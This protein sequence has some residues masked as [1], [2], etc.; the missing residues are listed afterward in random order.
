MKRWNKMVMVA[1]LAVGMA[2]GA[3][4]A[5]SGKVEGDL[6][7]P[8]KARAKASGGGAAK[9]VVVMS[10]GDGDQSVEVRLED[11]KVVGA[12][13]NGKEVPADRIRRK[14]GKVEILDTDGE[15]IQSFSVGGEGGAF[16]VGPEGQKL[17]QLLRLQDPHLF[18]GGGEGGEPWRLIAPGETFAPPKVML[19]INMGTPDDETTE[20]HGI[21]PAETILISKVIEGLP[22]DKAGI[23][24]GDIVVKIGGKSPATPEKL[25]ELLRDKDAGDTLKVTV[26]RDGEERTLTVELAEYDA[27]KLGVQIMKIEPGEGF[28][29]GQFKGPGR[30]ND[31]AFQEM[32]K[33]WQEQGF[34]FE[35]L[36]GQPGMRFRTMP[37]P[38]VGGSNQRLHN[39]LSELNGRMAEIDRR[40]SELDERLERLTQK[41]EKLTADRP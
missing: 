10:R 28:G 6:E 21:D 5:Q 13:V 32:M 29:E 11:G 4:W 16:W 26:L 1:G 22:A 2:G 38:G 8:M 23:K 18:Q 34:E 41:L 7:K 9:S 40:L 25:R 17:E 27:S 14:D 35:N 3:A 19:G 39:Q 36:P 15:V 33:K 31:K 12:K 24:E 30:W 37:P 20:K